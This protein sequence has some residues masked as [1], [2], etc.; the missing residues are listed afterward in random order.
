MKQRKEKLLIINRSFW[1]IYPVIGE[2]LLRFAE[3]KAENQE[4]GVVLQ[5]HAGIRQQLIKHNR[6]Q[7]VKFFPCKAWSISGSGI[8]RRIIDAIF[9]VLG[10][11]YS[12]VAASD[13]SVCIYGSAGYRAIYRDAL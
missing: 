5:D 7:G 13:K 10:A 6:G 4:V 3:R 8:F 12:A 2:A 9:Y 11:Y 1:P